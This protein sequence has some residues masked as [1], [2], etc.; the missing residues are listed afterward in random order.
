[1]TKRTQNVHQDAVA[2]DP[3]QWSEQSK[4]SVSFHFTREYVDEPYKCWR[5]G[6]ACIFA[7]QDQKYT[8]EVK[9][10]NIDQRRKFCT[11]CWSESHQLQA[12]LSKYDLR[13]A[14]EKSDLR[15]N[16]QFLNEWLELLTRWEQFAPYKQD[17]AKLDM[18]RR[19]LK[20][21]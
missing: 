21:E 17:V 12:A 9:K 11:A 19:L 15:S 18:L 7:A 2:A 14:A 13:W 4:H 10:A 1:M 5:C 6:S 16:R 8:F 20:R 3:D